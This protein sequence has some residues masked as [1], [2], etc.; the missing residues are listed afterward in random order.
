[1]T[2]GEPSD[3]TGTTSVLVREFLRRRAIDGQISVDEF[4]KSH[5]AADDGIRQELFRA[6]LVSRAARDAESD[7]WVEAIQRMNGE[8]SVLDEDVEDE[9]E[10]PGRS[11]SSAMPDIRMTLVESAADV[12]STRT[13]DQGPSVRSLAVADRLQPL[14]LRPG[15]RPPTPVLK[16]Y[17]DNQLSGELIRIRLNPFRIGRTKC[18]LSIPHDP[19]ISE[20]HAQLSWAERD[21]MYHWRLRDMSSVHGTYVKA[22]FARLRDGK[23]LRI[24]RH[25]FR[26]DGTNQPSLVDVTSGEPRDVVFLVEGEYWLGRDPSLCP[27][28]LLRDVMLDQK[29]AQVYKRQDGNWWIKDLGSQNGLWIET[30]DTQLEP[31]CSFL[32]GEQR[33][34]FFL[35]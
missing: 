21:G 9:A 33:F 5:P 22:Q 16:V 11:N 29:H 8:V 14:V 31:N 30:Q 27:S 34:G 13:V 26:Y 32:L 2:L 1:M 25:I 17:D 35:P 3:K 7:Q 23:R 10:A 4:L 18:D 20:T 15:L 12:R 28:F 19:W 6:L 24:G